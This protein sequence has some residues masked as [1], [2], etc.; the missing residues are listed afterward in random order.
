MMFN[1]KTSNVAEGDA[2]V[3]KLIV[4]TAENYLN[5]RLKYN[6]YLY[7][8]QVYEQLGL[9]WDPARDNQCYIYENGD[10]INLGITETEDGIELRNI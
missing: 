1:P 10:R 3:D 5:D 8:N 2:I 7:L 9:R 6:G 4:C